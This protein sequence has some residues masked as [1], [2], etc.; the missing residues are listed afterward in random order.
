MSQE[1]VEIVRRW[2]DGCNRRDMDT[3]IKLTDPDVEFRSIFVAMEADFR[4]YE[5]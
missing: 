2:N 5:A 4:G 3:L 1:N